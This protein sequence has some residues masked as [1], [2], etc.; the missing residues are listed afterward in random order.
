MNTIG[1]DVDS[2]FLVCQ[3]QRGDCEPEDAQFDNSKRG[4]LR[5]IRWATKDSKTAR[6]CMES[7]GV[8]SVPFALTLHETPAIEV[9]VVNP[10]V[11]K[12]FA[13]ASKQ[14]GKTDRMDATTIRE[15]A[16]RMP[17]EAW[18]PPSKEILEIQ[19]IC[20]RIVQLT[21]EVTRE[22]NRR[23]AALKLGDIGDVVANDTAV[24][25][26]HLKRRIV[27]LESAVLR[28]IQKSV[29]MKVFKYKN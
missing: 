28:L 5:F 11:M 12:K 13:E 23:K 14:R 16:A 3:I 25:V 22:D 1:V 2:K 17:F 26:R 18:S 8:Y 6:V 10:G 9:S 7:T 21:V 15:Y 19:H 4:F 29:T 24:T 20:R 27:I